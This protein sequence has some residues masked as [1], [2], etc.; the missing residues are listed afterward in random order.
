MAQNASDEKSI[1][2][3]GNRER[4]I[5]EGE[6][7]D[8]RFLIA[9]RQGRRFIWRFLAHCKLH[10]SVWEPSARIHYNAGV[11]D[12]GHFLLAEVLEAD[13]EAML[14]MM[15]EAKDEKLKNGENL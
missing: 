13:P 6:L 14:K 9:N 15:Q 8:I 11:Q 1:K 7:N 5:R 4:R 12:V 2:D 10:G 3:A